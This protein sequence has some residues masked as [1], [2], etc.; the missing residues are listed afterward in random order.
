MD[1]TPLIKGD[2]KIIN[3]YGAE[4]FVVSGKEHANS[5]ILS[6]ITVNGWNMPS[7]FVWN[8]DIIEQ[9]MLAAKDAEVVL[10]G[11]G[12]N[13]LP[14]PSKWRSLFR[15]KRISLD[16]MDTGAACRTYN[17]LLSEERRVIAALVVV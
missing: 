15:E 3:S 17:V 10:V 7:P 6:P 9:L 4:R 5:I 1:I 12:K 8:E 13:T 2:R 11:T 16:V 14:M